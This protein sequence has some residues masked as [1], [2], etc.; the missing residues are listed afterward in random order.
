[1]DAIVLAVTQENAD[2]LLDGRRTADHR[3]LPPTRL[4]A[5]AYLAV[6]GTAMVVGECVLGERAGR[7]AKGWTLPVTKPRRY[8]S[9]RPLAHFGLAKAPRSFRYVEK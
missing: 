9:A 6:V 8:R 5:R 7:T 2:A 4:P 1:M 3:A